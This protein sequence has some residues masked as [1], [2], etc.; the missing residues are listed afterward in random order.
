MSEYL[1]G[2]KNGTK[3]LC[4]ICVQNEQHSTETRLCVTVK[5]ARWAKILGGGSFRKAKS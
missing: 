3:P 1:V 5:N 2:T 4:P